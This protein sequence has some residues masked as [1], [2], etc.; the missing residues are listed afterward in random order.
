MGRFS[1]TPRPARPN[2]DRQDQTLSQILGV[3]QFGVQLYDMQQRYK[4][5]REDREL[6]RQEQGLEKE[7]MG[8]RGREV[9]VAERNVAVS[10]HQAGM[11]PLQK[12]A[13]TPITPIEFKTQRIRAEDRIK[14]QYGPAVLS[15]M[16]PMLNR[17]QVLVDQG[18]GTP[19][20]LYQQ[21]V[22]HYN[23][24][25]TRALTALEKEL[26]K[27]VLNP[28]PRP[29]P[30][31]GKTR[32]ESIGDA[33]TA[34]RGQ[35]TGDGQMKPHFA[36]FLN[37][38]GAAY[39]HRLS[40]GRKRD[41]IRQLRERGFVNPEE[42]KGMTNLAPK[43]GGAMKTWVLPDGST[44]NLPNDQAPPEGAVPYSTLAP[45]R[46]GAMKTWVLPD[47][48]TTNLPNDQAPPEGAV[49]YSTGMDIEVTE[50]GTNIRTG[51]GRGGTG[52]GGMSRTTQSAIEKDVIAGQKEIDRLSRIRAGYKPEFQQLGTRWTVLKTRWKEK[53]ADT[54][55][56]GVL[57]SE[58]PEADRKL[59]EEYSAYRQDAMTNLNLTIKYITGAQMSERE[60]K[61]LRQQVPNPGIGFF[62]GDSPTEFEAKLNASI[63]TA[64]KVMARNAMYLS[65]GLTQTQA[66]EIAKKGSG[67]LHISLED[68]PK[69][70]AQRA[71]ALRNEGKSDQEIAEILKQ[72]F[73]L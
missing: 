71:T 18:V 29:D 58:I 12:R 47:G 52:P 7:R 38:V 32:A 20:L 16:Q 36:A 33:I 49:P 1:P 53:L 43:R 3:A 70:M 56:A 69:I 51:V 6:T 64:K 57:P 5:G 4:A 63:E 50:D 26:E 2:V 28:D 8:L 40:Q 39:E 60:V 31:T 65:Q 11:G 54:P 9:G 42:A 44:T 67:P 22:L 48:S 73:G 27:E 21:D 59:L 55:L 66:T 30:A 41:A 15:A 45:K 23:E 37:P 24:E 72:E 14:R 13:M 68:V 34:I 17:R 35:Q 62:D 25:W 61:R 19:H 10:E 46:G